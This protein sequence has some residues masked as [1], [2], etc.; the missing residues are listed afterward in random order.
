MPRMTAKYR[1][2]ALIAQNKK[3]PLNGDQ[4]ALYKKLQNDGYF[5]D[6]KQQVWIFHDPKKAKPATKL[7]KIR[8]WADGSKVQG[9]AD[10]VARVLQDEFDWMLLKQSDLYENRPPEQNDGRVYLEFLPGGSQ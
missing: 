7:I 3:I 5:W 4:N 9:I 8:V 1:R 10:I 2:A 6:S